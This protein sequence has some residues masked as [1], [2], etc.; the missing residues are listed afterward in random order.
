MAS[1]ARPPLRI[2][3]AVVAGVIALLGAFIGVTILAFVGQLSALSALCE[4]VQADG[5]SCNAGYLG[6][7]TV[8]GMAIVVFA[9]ALSAGFA[10][11]RIIQRRMAWWLPLVGIVAMIAGFYLVALLAAAYQPAG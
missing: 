3:D 6:G 1:P 5:L 4:G 9:W 11:V 8:L 10:L 2:V 7:I